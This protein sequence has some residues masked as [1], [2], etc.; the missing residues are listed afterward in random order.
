VI[1][2]LYPIITTT[3]S[4]TTSTTSTSTTTSTTSTTT[5]TSST[6][7]TTTTTTTVPSGK[8]AGYCGYRSPYGCWCDEKCKQN[9]DCCDDVCLGCPGLSH[10]GGS[11]IYCAITVKVYNDST[12]NP[13]E[14]VFVTID[15]SNV[16]VTG[17]DGTVTYY[18]ITRGL[19]TIFATKANFIQA[20]QTFSCETTGHRE[21]VIRMYPY[22][23]T[24]TTST[25][26]STTSSTS[27]ISC[28][29][30]SCYNPS[31]YCD[32]EVM[33]YHGD[34]YN[35]VAFATVVLDSRSETTSNSGIAYFYNIPV[36]SHV[37]EVSK[38]GYY[39]RSQTIYCSCGETR[40][41]IIRLYP[42]RDPT[43]SYTIY[44]E[45]N[46]YCH[47]DVYVIDANTSS[48]IEKAEV[49]LDGSKKLLTSE[50]GKVEYYLIPS[51]WRSISVT[52]QGYYP[53]YKTFRCIENQRHEIVVR[54]VKNATAQE[55]EKRVNGVTSLSPGKCR[56]IAIA[57]KDYTNETLKNV[58]ITLNGYSKK[59]T[60]EEGVAIF[61][62]IALGTHTLKAIKED[63]YPDIRTAYCSK[64][65][66][67]IEVTF[68]LYPKEEKY[69]APTG[70][71]IF[72]VPEVSTITIV[73]VLLVLIL[74]A[75]L[76]FATPLKRSS[77]EELPG[78]FEI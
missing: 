26:T 50:N 73:I 39:S 54:L 24:S 29:S 32:I 49:K 9:G 15:G 35:P 14:G 71:I 69:K 75:F 61:E 28:P 58:E 3:T 40:R 12:N 4:T 16:K 10:C 23:T 8:C 5:T 38:S 6:T 25:T 78:D 41:V 19:H 51:G 1:L 17:N 37:I 11:E 66:E 72:Q 7:S 77:E 27:T 56:I 18:G 20:T 31:Q 57:I 63:Y 13:L 48:P 44:A 30:C 65:N 34:T 64:E 33:V 67:T 76:L 47:V 59:N 52:K 62:D 21:I 46:G 43:T 70:G 53:E 22:P 42:I 60:T 2:R 36:G 74:V 45:G 68:R 55:S